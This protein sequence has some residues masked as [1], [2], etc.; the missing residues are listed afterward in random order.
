MKTF[1]LTWTSGEG[2]Y[3]KAPTEKAAITLAGNGWPRTIDE[4][5]V[6]VCQHCKYS[7]V[8]ISNKTLDGKIVCP[9]CS[10]VQLR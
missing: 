5:E 9:R 4:V 6:V 1:Y 3:V 8:P 7:N 2:Q 10:T